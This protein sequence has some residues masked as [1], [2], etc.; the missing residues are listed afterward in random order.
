M[1]KLIITEDQVILRETLKYI[2]EQK[3]DIKVVGCAGNGKEALQ[4][5]RELMPDIVLMDLVMPGVD[6]LEG[7]KLIKREFP[8]VKV[9]I[10]TT[11]GDKDNVLRALEN[12]A[13]G[14]ILK[15]IEP[16]D[17]ISSIFNT[18]KGLGVIQEDILNQIISQIKSNYHNEPD[19]QDISHFSLTERERAIIKYITEGK[20]NKE[21][22]RFLSLAE[23]SVRNTVSGILIK[24]DL[25]DRVQLAVFGVK[26]NIA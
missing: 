12:G 13:D 4:L 5:C 14:Y 21:I 17:L 2:I 7:T 9:L 6:G 22:A 15:D 8:D 26:N 25:K 18:I 1:I 20:S 11:F 19:A 24:L 16:D 10:L 3:S 23:G